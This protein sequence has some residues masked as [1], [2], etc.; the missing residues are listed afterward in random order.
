LFT[1]TIVK[2]KVGTMEV[3]VRHEDLK[4]ILG[5]I[6]KQ[7]INVAILDETGEWSEEYYIV[8][9]VKDITNHQGTMTALLLVSPRLSHC[10]IVDVKSISGIKMNKYLNLNGTLMQE[11]TVQ[12]DEPHTVSS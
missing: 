11:L 1:G 7:Y 2:Q 4:D 10:S 12:S 5:E 3:S 8:E 6:K 9:G